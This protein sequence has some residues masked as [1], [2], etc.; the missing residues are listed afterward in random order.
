MALTKEDA[1]P[2]GEAWQ[3]ALDSLS[4]DQRKT[5]DVLRL[6]SNA[7]DPRFELKSIRLLVA[8]AIADPAFRA[9]LLSDADSVLKDLRG[10]SDLPDT[11]HVRF[12]E[13]S[14]DHLTVVLPPAMEARSEKTKSVRDLIISRTMSDPTVFSVGGTDDNDVMPVTMDFISSDHDN[15]H[16]G[17]PSTDGH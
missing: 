5:L 7:I 15:W 14:T 3:L 12:V 4:D 11:L 8:R 13:N 10:H 6:T 16:W 9:V 1:T 17:D 2:A